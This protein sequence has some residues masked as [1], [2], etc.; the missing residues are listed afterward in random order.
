MVSGCAHF[1]SASVMSAKASSSATMPPL[2][3]MLSMTELKVSVTASTGM[4]A[5][6][7]TPPLQL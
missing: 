5:R 2:A 6:Q 7:R 1:S 4:Q 3:V